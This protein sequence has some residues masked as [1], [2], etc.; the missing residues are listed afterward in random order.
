MQAMTVIL[1][2]VSVPVLSEQMCVAEPIVSEE[3]RFRTKLLSSFILELEKLSEMV[4]ASGRP[5]GIAHTITEIE[6]MMPSSMFIQ[7]L[8]PSSKPNDS[9]MQPCS[10]WQLIIFPQPQGIHLTISRM[11]R[12]TIEQNVSTAAK[13]PTCPILPAITSNLSC[14]S[15][16]YFSLELSDTAPAAVFNPTDVTMALP[17]P[18][19]HKDLANSTPLLSYIS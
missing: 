3:F 19:T 13:I 18:L 8:L 7:N 15:V 9:S 1:F 16:S 5:S 10:A 6:M 11:D 4:T 12:M 14:K 2:W 17:F